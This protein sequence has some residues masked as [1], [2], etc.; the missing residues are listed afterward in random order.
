[1]PTGS[2]RDEALAAHVKKEQDASAS[3]SGYQRVEAAAQSEQSE[4]DPKQPV[5]PPL[6]SKLATGQAYI[7][8]GKKLVEGWYK[9]PWGTF[10]WPDAFEK[11]GELWEQAYEVRSTKQVFIQS[12]P[13]LCG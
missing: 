9:T 6:A 5:D 3:S 12:N 1:M 10:K 4:T 11:D 2:Q 8:A 13:R 7:E